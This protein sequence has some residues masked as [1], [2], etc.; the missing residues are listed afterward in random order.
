MTFVYAICLFSHVYSMFFLQLKRKLS[1]G[2][3]F[4]LFTAVSSAPA[5]CLKVLKGYRKNECRSLYLGCSPALLCL[6]SSHS[7][8]RRQSESLPQR[9]FT[10]PSIFC[11]ICHLNP[12]HILFFFVTTYHSCNFMLICMI[13]LIM[14]ILLLDFKLHEGRSFDSSICF[15]SPWFPLKVVQG[16]AFGRQ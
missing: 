8:F 5:Q 16:P 12:F 14:I 6:I 10:R 15:C 2:K 9:S 3:E 1:V 4:V 13:Q 11:L 7:S